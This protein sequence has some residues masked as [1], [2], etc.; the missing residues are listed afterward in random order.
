MPCCFFQSD[1]VR[2]VAFR[3]AAGAR[4]S[5]GIEVLNTLTGSWRLFTAVCGKTSTDGEALQVSLRE[6]GVADGRFLEVCEV[7]KTHVRQM[8]LTNLAT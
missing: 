6:V 1:G 4:T 8:V 2:Y 5:E 7:L 3:R